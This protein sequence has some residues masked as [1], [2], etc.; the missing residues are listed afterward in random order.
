MLPSFSDEDKVRFFAVMGGVPYYLSQVDAG[1]SFEENIAGLFF[2]VDGNLF[3]E[4]N[5]LMKQE[6]D[7][8]AVYNAVIMVGAGKAVFEKKVLPML[9]DFIG[10]TVFETVCTQYLIRQLKEGSLSVIPTSIGRWW[11][12]DDLRQRQSDIDIVLGDGESAILCECKWRNDVEVKSETKKL[13]DKRRF[14]RGYRNFSFYLFGK[15]PFGED[16]LAYAKEFAALRLVSLG[17]MMHPNP[18]DG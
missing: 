4:P 8:P 16:A 13:L 14:L 5:F 2:R 17:D 18:H 6:F 12:N 9:D 3:D 7:L 1:K 15:K 10:S 11:G